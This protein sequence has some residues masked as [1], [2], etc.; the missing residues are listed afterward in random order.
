MLRSNGH[1][2]LPA[3]SFSLDPAWSIHLTAPVPSSIA[4]DLEPGVPEWGGGAGVWYPCKSVSCIFFPKEKNEKKFN[5]H[6]L[7]ANAMLTPTLD[8]SLIKF[9]APCFPYAFLP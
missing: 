4:V 2:S 8:V 1:S 6:L 7:D 9:R 3:S 5:S